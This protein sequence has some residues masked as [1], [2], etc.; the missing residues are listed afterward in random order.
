MTLLCVC[1]QDFVGEEIEEVNVG[2]SFCM[3]RGKGGDCFVWGDGDVGQLG[4]GSFH[5][6]PSIAIN[7]SFPGIESVSAGGNHAGKPFMIRQ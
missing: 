2:A 5:H 1:V 7:N 6:S 3:A 4:L